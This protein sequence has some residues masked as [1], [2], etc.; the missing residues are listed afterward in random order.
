MPDRRTIMLSA[1][2]A[3]GDLHGETL[4]RALRALDPD[5][6]L[7][8]MGGPRMAAAGMEVVADPT[9][10]AVVGMTEA[11]GRVP[12]LYGAYRALL[13]RIRAQRPD[14]LVLIDFPEFNMRL[15]RAASRAGVRV[16]YFV[17]PQLWAWRPGRA[18][19]IARFVTRVLT[20]LPF[21]REIYE[22]VHAPVEYTGHPLL[23]VLPLDLTRDAARERLGLDPAVSLIGLLPGS[24]R[25]EVDRLLPAMLEA[26][27][28]LAALDP[29]RRFLLGAAPTVDTVQ[30]GMLLR[31][32]GEAGGPRVEIVEGLT[33]ELM[34][35][36]DVLMIASGTATLEAALLNTPMVVC[37]RVSR[38]TEWI[39][40]RLALLPWI[41]LPNIIVRRFAVP[42]LL[43]GQV[44]ERL[45]YETLRLLEDSA[46]ITAQRA[47][48]KDIRGRLGE[49]GV[50]R[51]AAKAVLEVA[52]GR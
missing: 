38:T 49:P 3:S 33:H 26:A 43:Q 52:R 35:A 6:S 31:A 39:G 45:A 42:E 15:G 24:R 29:R 17:P 47:A 10:H 41:S 5:V 8:G 18:R 28:K 7:V 2:E 30:V 37:Y 48:F 25:K 4:C 50:G 23:D 9:G 21:E 27:G 40:R 12:A 14:A 44:S 13:R 20:V 1:G 36:A 32:A 22:A 11:V 51:R 46:T 16:V 34:A 19:R